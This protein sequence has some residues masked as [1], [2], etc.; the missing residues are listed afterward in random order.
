MPMIDYSTLFYFVNNNQRK[1]EKETAEMD[2]EPS[3]RSVQNILD[4]A[5]C[6]EALETEETGYVEMILN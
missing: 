2:Y 3:E 5:R 6:Y 4:F 1:V